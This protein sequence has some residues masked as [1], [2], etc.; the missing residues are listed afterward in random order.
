MWWIILALVLGLILYFWPKGVWVVLGATVLIGGSVLFWNSHKEAERATAVFT[1]TYAPDICP[2][3]RPMQVSLRNTSD[4]T[5]ERA[6]FTIHATM[7]GYSSVITPYTYR[8]NSSDKILAPGEAYSACYPVPVLTRT[9]ADAIS[10]DSLEWSATAD[11][12]FFQ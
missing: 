4:K 11:K 2:D 10:L 1:V 9:K 8:Q 7:P 3:G 12:V 5:M 6:L